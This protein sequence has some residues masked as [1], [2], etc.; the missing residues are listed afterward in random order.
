M[1]MT[2]QGEP[3]DVELGSLPTNLPEGS[4]RN[5]IDQAIA[6]MFVSNVK[7]EDLEGWPKVRR[8]RSGHFGSWVS[9]KDASFL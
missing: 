3:N 6:N 1:L 7:V 4:N 2:R 9:L 5:S 8:K